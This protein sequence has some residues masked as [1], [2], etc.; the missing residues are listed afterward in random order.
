MNKFFACATL[1]AAFL[2]TK[3][4]TSIAQ[5]PRTISYQGVLTDASGKPVSPDGR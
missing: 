3:P 4:L 5:I 2:G 1:V